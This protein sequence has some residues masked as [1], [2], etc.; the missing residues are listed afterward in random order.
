MK[1]IV[2][3]HKIERDELLR[4]DFVL[5]EGISDKT[6]VFLRKLLYKFRFP[7]ENGKF[8]AFGTCFTL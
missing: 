7:N 1:D 2:L 6:L 8:F 3:G 4:Q 5:R